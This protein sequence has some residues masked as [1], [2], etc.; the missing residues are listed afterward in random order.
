MIIGI[1]NKL[2]AAFIKDKSYRDTAVNNN[3]WQ[4]ILVTSLGVTALVWGVRELKWLQSWELKAYDQMLRS[5]PAEPPDSRIL[6]VTITEEDL[7]KKS[8]TLADDTINRLLAKLA[9]YQPRVIA[10]NLYRPEQKNLG[11]GLENPTNIISAC[12]SSSMGRSEIP[13]PPNFPP[14]NIGYNDVISDIESDQ[15]V[16]R[17]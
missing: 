11:M 9:S 10:L 16:R 3:W 4:I 15:V 2:R 5:R 1:S 14:E 13:P 12:L 6:L 8:W 17:G 7:A